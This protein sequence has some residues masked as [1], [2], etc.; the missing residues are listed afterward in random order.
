MDIEVDIKQ[1][2]LHNGESFFVV[3]PSGLRIYVANQQ[4]K[5]K[6]TNWSQAHGGEI[7]IAVAESDGSWTVQESQ[8]T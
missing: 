3:T 2:K 4:G 5:L 6:M 1:I 8:G 7:G